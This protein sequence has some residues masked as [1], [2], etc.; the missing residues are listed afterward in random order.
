M[1]YKQLLLQPEWILKRQEIL[2]RDGY[3]CTECGIERPILRGLVKSFGVL[4]LNELKSRGYEVIAPEKENARI[5][6]FIFL[7]DG[8]LN[9]ALFIGKEDG[10]PHLDSLKFSL[11]CSNAI[12]FG[13]VKKTYY[14]VAFYAEAL[15]GRIYIDLNIHHNYYILGNKPWEYKNE[16]LTSLCIDCHKKIHQLNEIFVYNQIGD[17]LFL[18]EICGRCNGTGYLKEFA[19]YENGICFQCTGEGVY[20]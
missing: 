20:Y 19:H 4:S 18:T 12:V 13:T 11:R 15:D 6:D 10:P 17:K 8:Y 9:K 3:K 14:L 7:K 1:N 16:A 5:E 2:V